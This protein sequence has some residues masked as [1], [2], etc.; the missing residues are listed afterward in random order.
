MNGVARILDPQGAARRQPARERGRRCRARTC[1]G[2]EEDTLRGLKMGAQAYI[3]KPFKEKE[4][5]TMID[6]IARP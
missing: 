6:K 1:E 3:T 4:L 5:R 2:R